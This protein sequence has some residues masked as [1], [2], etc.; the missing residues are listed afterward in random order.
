MPG[1]NARYHEFYDD[2]TSNIED[3]FGF[4]YCEITTKQRYLGLLP[5]RSEN[6]GL[7]FPSGKWCG[8]Y[9]SE[10]LKFAKQNGYNIRMIKGYNFDSVDSVFTNYVNDLYTIKSNKENKDT[11]TSL[12]AKSLLNNLLGRFGMDFTKPI[13][14]I[15]AFKDIDNILLKYIVSNIRHIHND[16]YLVSYSPEEV[17]YQCTKMNIDMSELLNSKPS[18]KTK[19]SDTVSL[20]ISAAITSY[21]RMHISKI[22]LEILK[23]GGYVYYSDTDSVVTNKKLDKSFIGS[24]IGKLKLE[25]IISK[26]YFISSKTYCFINSENRLIKRAKD[27]DSK[28]MSLDD[29]KMLNID[30][31][32]DAIQKFSKTNYSTGQV[33]IGTKNIS[34]NPNSYIKREKVYVDSKWVDTTSLFIDETETLTNSH[35]SSTNLKPLEQNIFP[36]T[37]SGFKKILSN[38]GVMLLII[39]LFILSRLFSLDDTYIEDELNTQDEKNSDELKVI[40]VKNIQET[41]KAAIMDENNKSFKEYETETSPFES[42]A[43]ETKN[44]KVEIVETEID[45]TRLLEVL[46]TNLENFIKNGTI[47]VISNFEGNTEI[48][49]K[50]ISQMIVDLNSATNSEKELEYY[51]DSS[52]INTE[53]VKLIR[54]GNDV[55]VYISDS[56]SYSS[57]ERALR[58]FTYKGEPYNYQPLGKEKAMENLENFYKEVNEYKSR[59]VVIITK[60]TDTP[61]PMPSWHHVAEEPS[62]YDDEQA[63]QEWRFNVN[64]QKAWARKLPFLNDQYEQ[65]DLNKRILD[66]TA[67]LQKTNNEIK[68]ETNIFE[69]DENPHLDKL[70]KEETDM[71]EKDEDLCLDKLF[72]ETK[73]KSDIKSDKSNK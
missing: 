60:P 24:V 29:Y 48:D 51:S 62:K 33:L 4:W 54:S 6:K 50:K 40:D 38:M 35:K 16:K 5:L 26:G 22:K 32:I 3:F 64:I 44:V 53:I 14:D 72:D 30:S 15:V 58:C 7:I 17:L 71:L 52:D 21:G 45:E 56:E 41:H 13:S 43:S 65:I 23:L 11:T 19:T 57:T 12:I 25:H 2:T 10:Q 28:L 8:W 36:N 61:L 34:L 63:Y 46:D 1:L 31:P 49:I 70:F 27:V 20:P 9:F 39:L 73:H 69:T 68:E 59:K 66:W 67:G 18:L 37:F 55:Q 42:E 47:K